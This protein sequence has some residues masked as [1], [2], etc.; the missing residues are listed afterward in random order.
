MAAAHRGCARRRQGHLHLRAQDRWPGRGPDLPERCLR[1]RRHAR[2]RHH[3]RGREPEHPHHPRRADAPSGGRARPHGRGPPH[4]HRGPW[5]GLHA[6][7][8]LRT[9]ECRGRC[10]GQGALRQSAQ[11]RRGKP[12]PEGPQGHRP[13]RPCHLHL[14]HRGHGPPPRAL[15]AR[16]PGLAP[17]RWLLGEP[18]R[19]HLLHAGR[20]ACLLRRRACAPRGPRLRHRRRGGEGR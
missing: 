3:G 11:R 18:E 2:R 10:R 16:V 14:R 7:G 9:A 13:A 15:P 8:Q 6:Q 17:L 19:L 20:G 4:A 5:R 1:A 12:A